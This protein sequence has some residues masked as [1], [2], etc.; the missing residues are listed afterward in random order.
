MQTYFDMVEFS[1]CGSKVAK[2]FDDE[3]L[4]DINEVLNSGKLDKMDYNFIFGI[5][6]GLLR[7]IIDNGNE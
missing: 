5:K 4:E 7:R 1:E 6:K 2:C 3:C